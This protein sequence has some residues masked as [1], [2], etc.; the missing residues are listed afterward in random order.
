MIKTKD[1]GLELYQDIHLDAKLGWVSLGRNWYILV[2]TYFMRLYYTIVMIIV[3]F[4]LCFAAFAA[5]LS[6]CFCFV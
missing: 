6:F 1:R 3:F 5:L 4:L 2:Q